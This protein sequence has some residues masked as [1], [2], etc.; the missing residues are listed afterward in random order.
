MT[1]IRVLVVD[2]EEDYRIVM[3]GHLRRKGYDVLTAEDGAEAL[4]LLREEGDV[5][6]LV[7]DLMMPE[8]DGLE[9]LDHAKEDDPYLEVVVI[10]GAGT[11]ESAISSMRE[12]GAYDYLPKPLDTMDDLSLA[13]GRAVE[14][15][16]LQIEQERL[17]AQIAAERERLQWVIENTSDALLSSEDGETIS[18]ANPAAEELFGL[19]S[20]VDAAAVQELPAPVA[21]LLA[22]W[23]EFEIRRPTVTEVAWPTD[24]VQ[25]VSL[26][27]SGDEGSGW[28]M[29]LRDVTELRKLQRLKMRLL[30]QT[31][32]EVRERLAGA[33]STMVELNEL[34]QSKDERFTGAVQLAMDDLSAIRGW[35]DEVLNLAEIEA[36]SVE[37]ES[38]APL[39]YLVRETTGS[40]L[41]EL[42]EEKGIELE[43]EVA[44]VD[45]DVHPGIARGLLQHLI[46]QAAWRAPSGDKLKMTLEAKH[47]QVWLTLADGGPELLEGQGP[48]LFDSFLG[49]ETDPQ[50]VIGLSLA[51]VKSTADALGAQVWLQ[52][53]PER[54]N[55]F[56]IS[57]P[58]E[59]TEPEGA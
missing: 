57:F 56:V 59:S 36:G 24:R 16:T 20:L 47:R 27:A 4:Q 34:P 35:T 52:S 53:G 12:G 22:N 25:M 8:M 55:A 7:T 19:E 46:Q 33:F 48:D 38:A 29:L 51:M 3:S 18:L 2:D 39:S 26:T 17:Q 21:S 45:C 41:P 14:H 31:A 49:W 1:D 15:R 5:E 50:P 40:E 54:G 11:L 42:L 32:G 44:D 10:S 58:L 6:I 30:I 9:L 28:V 13:V 43:A 37:A 23:I